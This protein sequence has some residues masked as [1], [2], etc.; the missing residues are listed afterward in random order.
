MKVKYDAATTRWFKKHP[1]AQTTV[2]QCEQ[3]GLYYKPN[4]GHVCKKAKKET[5]NDVI[6]A[7]LRKGEPID[8]DEMHKAMKKAVTVHTEL[9]TCELCKKEHPVKVADYGSMFSSVPR[10]NHFGLV[11]HNKDGSV[12]SYSCT[13]LC[14]TCARSILEYIQSLE[15]T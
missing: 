3:C 14:P 13:N 15:V 2:I 1:D 11:V 12:V 5:L 4:L 6:E 8:F 9:H 10:N 7:K